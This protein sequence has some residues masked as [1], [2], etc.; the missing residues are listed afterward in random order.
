MSLN[1]ASLFYFINLD[2]SAR[3][4]SNNLVNAPTYLNRIKNNNLSIFLILYYII[5]DYFQSSIYGVL[6]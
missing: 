4:Y 5:N 2:D 3:R 6:L 1:V